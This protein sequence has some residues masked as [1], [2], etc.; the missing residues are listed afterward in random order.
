MGIF[1]VAIFGILGLMSQNLAAARRLQRQDMD[2]TILAAQLSLTNRLE[3][4]FESGDFG[5]VF[6]D[7]LW[8]RT[9][10]EVSSNGLVP[11]RLHRAR[12]QPTIREA[13]LTEQHLSILM[14]RP[15]RRGRARTWEPKAL[16]TSSFIELPRRT[17]SWAPRQLQTGH[18]RPAPDRAFTLVEVM[19]AMALFAMVMVAIYSSWTA[20]LRGSKVGLDA[21]AEAQRSRVAVRALRDALTSGSFTW[22]ISRYYWFMAD[23]SGEFRRPEP[24][25][26]VARVLPGQRAVWKPD[27]ASRLLHG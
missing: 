26:A 14:Y 6:P 10:T 24:G 15:I 1:F 21:A 2:I 3:E 19:V 22:R 11:R 4:G 8:S 25:L 9:I 20:I 18:D 16:M 17:A 5:D 13:P 12:S 7:A 27:R 23:T